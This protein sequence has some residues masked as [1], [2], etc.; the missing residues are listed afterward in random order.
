MSFK[1][2]KTASWDLKATEDQTMG[3]NV[4]NSFFHRRLISETLDAV[5]LVTAY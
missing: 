1:K 4:A 2:R 3:G 5:K